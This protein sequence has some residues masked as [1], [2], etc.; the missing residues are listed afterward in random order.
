MI[1][2]KEKYELR[3]KEEWSPEDCEMC[4]LNQPD[5]VTCSL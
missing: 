3:Q 2:L 4:H 1:V 5:V